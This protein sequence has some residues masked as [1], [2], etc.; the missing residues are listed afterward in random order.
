MEENQFFKPT[1]MYKEFMILDFIH[2][3]KYI[4]QRMICNHLNV[5]VSM[6][7]KYI[8][9][10][11]MLGNLKKK[12]I[13]S[14]IIYYQ[15]TKKGINRKKILNIEYLNSSQIIYS[16]AKENIVIFL[17]KIVKNGFQRLILYGA[18]EVAEIILQVIINDKLIPLQVIAIID[19]ARFK[20]GKMIF[21]IP[22]ISRKEVKSFKYDAVLISSY[23]DDL[24][25]YNKLKKNYFDLD[26]III[27]LIS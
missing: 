24:E 16:N 23:T 27:F 3:N 19:D 18:G 14:K 10:Y 20:Q 6:I 26:K 2:K 11:V 9:D 7:N 12:Y 15:L 4:T 25:I 8:H 22:I 5:S 17:N 13:S 1:L 21:S